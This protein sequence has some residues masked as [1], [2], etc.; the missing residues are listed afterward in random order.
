MVKT[1]ILH[2]PWGWHCI[3]LLPWFYRHCRTQNAAV[4]GSL[5]CL[6]K[7]N[8]FVLSLQHGG[9]NPCS[10]YGGPPPSLLQSISL[11]KWW[12][13]C[14]LCLFSHFCPSLLKLQHCLTLKHWNNY[15]RLFS[16]SLQKLSGWFDV[17]FTFPWGFR[18]ST[19]SWLNFLL[20]EIS[21]FR[22]Q[23][24]AWLSLACKK[25]SI[26]FWMWMWNSVW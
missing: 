1:H 22:F 15:T 3:L 16:F 20:F 10:F 11:R 21:C 14:L 17:F 18:Q 4:A 5:S 19:W 6:A 2:A 7:C 13:I 25:Y 8:S 12:T 23:E 9:Y 26:L 24:L